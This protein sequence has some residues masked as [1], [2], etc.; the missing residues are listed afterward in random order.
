MPR[1]A[2]VIIET[3]NTTNRTV[4]A[5][6]PTPEIRQ[7]HQTA[8]ADSAEATDDCG[9]KRWAETYGPRGALAQVSV[10]RIDP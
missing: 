6:E 8:R 7:L 2:V 3:N 4:K 5:N 9:Y 10:E 1:F